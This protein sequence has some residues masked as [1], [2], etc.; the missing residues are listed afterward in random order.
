MTAFQ[1]KYRDGKEEMRAH[2]EADKQ[3][4]VW[5]EWHC[6]NAHTNNRSNARF[7]SLERS[8]KT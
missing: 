5:V 1:S 3:V 8:R 6:P 7:S 4:A 2:E